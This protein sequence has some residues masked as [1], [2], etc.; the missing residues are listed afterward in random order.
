[1][2]E[3]H[4]DLLRAW[5]PRKTNNQIEGEDVDIDSEVDDSEASRPTKVFGCKFDGGLIT[6]WKS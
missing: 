2:R 4:F 5:V 3:T 6:R 1:M